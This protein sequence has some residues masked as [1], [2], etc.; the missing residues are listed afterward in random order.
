[1]GFDDDP[2]QIRLANFR[3]RLCERFLYEYDFTVPWQHDLRV[4]QIVVADAKRT[5]PTGIGGKR[6]APPEDCGG[7]V[8]T[9]LEHY[10]PVFLSTT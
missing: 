5:Y 6:A 10:P 4:E 8:D 7:K 2:K 3:L 1:M 9:K